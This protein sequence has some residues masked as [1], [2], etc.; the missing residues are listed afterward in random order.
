MLPR[1]LSDHRRRLLLTENHIHSDRRN[2]VYSCRSGYYG[3]Q[4][5]HLQYQGDELPTHLTP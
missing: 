1:L 2:R 5:W 3:L 4:L